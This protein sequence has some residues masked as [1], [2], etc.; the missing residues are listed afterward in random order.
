MNYY[1]VLGIPKD[2]NEDQIKKAYRAL[3]LKY[4]PD[5]NSD[6]EA[7]EKFKEINE[8]NEILSDPDKRRQYEMSQSFGNGIPFGGGGNGMEFHDIHSI[9]NHFFS[10]G[11]MGGGQGIHIVQGMNG[12]N[13][14]TSFFKNLS[15]PP[16]IIKNIE[17]TLEQIFS[18]C[19]LKIELDRWTIVQNEKVADPYTI[20]LTI[21][22]GIDENEI[23]VL[24]ELGH[25]IND[26]VKGDV[27]IM[28]KTI[29]NL[30][31][32]RYG[33]DIIYKKSVT[34]K[35]ALCG[36]MFELKYLNDKILNFNNILNP[37]IIKPNFKKII[38]RMG[39]NKNGNV[40]NLIIEFDIVF[41]DIITTEQ[42]QLLSEIL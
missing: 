13:G 30:L 6:P 27:K 32:S 8:A 16:P 42:M 29:P 31:F 5:R 36:F 12:G 41:P 14:F 35:E 4:H 19:V 21:P 9:F 26:E 15:K 10:H 11:P 18:G 38:P 28:M 37:T 22:P 24:R 2:A 34:L 25:V 23:I 3:S 7:L 39:L 20:D 17:L 40:G 33:L 1:E